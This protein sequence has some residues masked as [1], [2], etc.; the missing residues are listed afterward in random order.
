MESELFII[1]RTFNAPAE[2]VWQAI[3][4][5]DKM[6]QWYFKLEEFRPEVGF[7]FRFSGGPE[8]RSYLHICVVTE[9]VPGEKLK[10]SWRYDGYAGLSYITWELF[11][12]GD[13]TKVRLTHTGLETFPKDPDF[14]R[15]NFATGWTHIV[16][17]SLAEYLKKE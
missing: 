15:T 14:E 4:H 12:D 16:G 5:R 3:T 2:K 9:V 17:T 1:E 7:E 6:E 8:D 10:H 13:K 11:P